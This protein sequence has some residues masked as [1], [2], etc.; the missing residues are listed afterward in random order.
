MMFSIYTILIMTMLLS[1]FSLPAHAERPG[2]LA[3]GINPGTLSVLQIDG[4]TPE[5]K[6]E[7]PLKHTDVKIKVSGFVAS[8]QV[9]QHYHNPF[10]K[11]IEAVYTFPLPNDAAVDDMQMTIGQRTIKGLIKRREEAR[12]IYERAREQGKRAS[13]LEQERPNIFTQSVANIMPGDNITMTIRYVNILHYTKGHYELVFPM[14]V[15]PRYIPGNVATGHQGTGH[16]PDTDVVPDASRIT[17]PVIK[18][19]ERSGHDIALSVKLEA[20]VAMKNIQSSSHVVDRKWISVSKA[21]VQLHKADSIP[22]KDFVLRYQVAGKVPEIA[23]I[24]HHDERGGFFTLIIQPQYT[25]TDAEVLPREL[26]FIV[27]TSGSMRGF[28]MEKSKQAMRQLIKGMRTTDTFNVVRFAGDAGTLWKRPKASTPD[29]VNEALRYVDSFRG[30]GGTEMRQGILEALAQ[31]AA[32]GYLRIAFLLTDGYVGNE[33][34]IFQAIEKERR[35][36]RVFSFGVGSSPNR[37]LLDRAA[38][39]GRGEAFYVRQDENSDKVINQFFQR[40]DRPALAHIDIDWGKLDVTDFYPAKVP[41][42][43]AGQPIRIHG[44]YRQGGQETIVVRGQLKNKPFMQKVRVQLPKNATDHEA[45]ATVW[46]RQKVRSLMTQM[47]REGRTQELIEQVTQLGLTFRLMTQWTSFVAVEEKIVNVN[48]Q[49][50]TVVQPVE[51]PE[52]VSYEGVFGEPPAPAPMAAISK[53]LTR[54][55]A[56]SVRSRARSAPALSMPPIRSDSASKP[57]YQAQTPLA[58]PPTISENRLGGAYKVKPTFPSSVSE[59]EEVVTGAKK[60][61]APQVAQEKRKA[62]DNSITFESGNATLTDRV[63]RI[64]DILAA[65][66]CREM[67]YINTIVITGHADSS[68][69]DDYKQK[70]SLARAVAVADY[71]KSRCPAL[72]DERLIIRGFADQYPI[73]RDNAENRRVEIRILR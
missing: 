21:N 59:D 57:R 26:I 52:G 33:F 72:T 43:W 29:N 23:T 53:G 56:P 73:S 45:M 44:R 38:E 27:D 5:Q 31:P 28:P 36:A 12:E 67:A 18:P 20:G 51:M 71:L 10:E 47:V 2:N 32:D 34:G 3:D 70:L 46:A 9:T 41:D 62:E 63:K 15:G 58:A 30:R 6:L 42:L 7:L 64:L 50:Q 65:K 14:V 1:L 39:I 69:A 16:S 13:L 4:K 22:N 54:G 37:Y 60:E 49:P 24:A 19:G 68:P 11:P 61:Q 35:G 8:A 40:V 48:G 66:I 17:P 55:F 25:V